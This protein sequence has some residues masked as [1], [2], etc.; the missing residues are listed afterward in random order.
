M[1]SDKEQQPDKLE[2]QSLP[3]ITN[4][5]DEEETPDKEEL[6]F[7]EKKIIGINN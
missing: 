3:M 2:K 7:K 5:D 6:G 1:I 4:I